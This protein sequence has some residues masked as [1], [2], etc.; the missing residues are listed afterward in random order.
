VKSNPLNEPGHIEDGWDVIDSNGKKVGEVAK[1]LPDHFTMDTGPF[2]L[3]RNYRVPLSAIREARD[4]KVFLSVSKEQV[5]KEDWSFESD[6]DFAD[7]WSSAMGYY[8][9]RWQERHAGES[10][11]GWEEHEPA[12]RFSYER[13]QIVEH[14]G[15]QWGQIEPQF[16]RDWESQHP[17]KP[18]DRHSRSLR[19]AWES[20]PDHEQRR[21][22]GMGTSTGRDTDFTGGTVSRETYTTGRGTESRDYQ[23]GSTPE[24]DFGKTTTGGTGF[25]SGSPRDTGFA[26]GPSGQYGGGNWSDVSSQYRSR[27]QTRHGNDPSHRWED[28]EPT[29][30]YSWE[31]NNR[32]EYRGKRWNEVEPNFRRDWERRGSDKPWDRVANSL[33]EAWEDFS[34]D[35]Q[36]RSTSREDEAIGHTRT[37]GEGQFGTST[38]LTEEE[39]RRRERG[40]F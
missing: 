29:Y 26:G 11:A 24:R 1:I 3:G 37:S 31:M 27:W 40:S 9:S 33:R 17:D 5:E 20:F 6:K 35:D 34:G 15:K 30:R 23:T 13:H 39:R 25:T 21:R 16:R 22:S 2:G 28:D 19:E 14:R 38:D 7:P 36:A 32:P 12:Y 18:W 10:G 4:S 8:K